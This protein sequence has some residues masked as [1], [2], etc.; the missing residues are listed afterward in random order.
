MLSVETDLNV[1]RHQ[2]F[3]ALSLKMRVLFSSEANPLVFVR[4]QS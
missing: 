3:K 2:L 1:Y 4:L